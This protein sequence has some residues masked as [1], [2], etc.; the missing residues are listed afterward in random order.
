MEK[1]LYKYLVP[2]HF[3]TQQ[4]QFELK[5]HKYLIPCSK[6]AL[7]RGESLNLSLSNS[8]LSPLVLVGM[9]SR[10]PDAED[11]VKVLIDLVERCEEGELGQLLARRHNR[12][13]KVVVVVS[14]V[15]G[16]L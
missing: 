12:R 16:R 1:A 8:G 14:G 3:G 9:R 7:A 4:V 11:V 10:V 2:T 5:V 6:Q 15:A 13:Q